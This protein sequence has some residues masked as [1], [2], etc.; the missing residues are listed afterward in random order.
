MFFPGPRSFAY[1]SS[2]WCIQTRGSPFVMG[3]SAER[4]VILNGTPLT[5]IGVA[6]RNFL[7]LDVFFGPDFWIPATMGE[8]IL[9][10]QF[11]QALTDHSKDM[12]QVFGRL[13]PGTSA[14]TA[15]SEMDALSVAVN[16]QYG[17]R[18][19]AAR[20]AVRPLLHELRG[21]DSGG[22]VIRSVVLLAIVGLLLAALYTPVW[23]SAIRGPE[24]FAVGIVAFL[25]LMFWKV[26][27]WLVIVLGALARAGVAIVV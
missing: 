6:P 11:K 15:N 27:P 23:T 25:L 4:T 14:T 21:G 26:P 8:T 24:D 20:I 13:R 16:Q 17:D 10:T 1:S 18:S 9:P 2:P 19:D 7:G 22:L 12:F 3:W 5:I